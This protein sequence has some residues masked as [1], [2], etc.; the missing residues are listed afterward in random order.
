MVHGGAAAP[1]AIWQ[2]PDVTDICVRNR[3]GWAVDTDHWATNPVGWG[4]C[5]KYNCSKP[6][7][8]DIW[9]PTA[10]K[11]PSEWARDSHYEID[12]R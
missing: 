1:E 5:S 2:M 3:R 12:T 8:M 10:V 6:I 11:W 7:R 4:S 9:R